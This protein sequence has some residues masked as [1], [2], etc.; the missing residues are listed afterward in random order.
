MLT[1]QEF[2]AGAGETTIVTPDHGIAE[3][4]RAA[5]LQV[6]EVA[7]PRSDAIALLAYKKILAGQTVSAEALDANY[8]R[9]SDAE[10]FAK[11]GG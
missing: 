1:L 9:R 4:A 10:I 11:G 3:A 5:R 6:E 8:V 7:R 2:L